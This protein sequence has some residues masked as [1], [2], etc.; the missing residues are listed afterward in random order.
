MQEKRSTINPTQTPS[1]T[2]DA[3]TSVSDRKLA[4]NRE[5]A[6]KSTGPRTERGKARSSQNA[7]RHG[8]FAKPLYP[9]AAQVTQDRSDYDSM[10]DG[11]LEHYQPV[12]YIEN[13]L[14]EKIAAGYL[15]SA[16][17]VRH[18]QVIFAMRYPFEVRSASSLPRYQTAVERQLE[19]DIERLESLQARRR[20]EAAS[21]EAAPETALADVT[22]GE[23]PAETEIDTAVAPVGDTAEGATP[24][25][26]ETTGDQRVGPNGGDQNAG[27]NPPA[28]LPEM[29]DEDSGDLPAISLA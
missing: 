29:S 10:V 23:A 27:T 21:I 5:N 6:K 2:A 26:P 4:A 7:Y 12:C 24:A 1:Q 17:I 22:D 11:L 20:A 8:F 13:V 15:R 18:E 9:T 14:V 28:V 25:L 16:R 19:K 3:H